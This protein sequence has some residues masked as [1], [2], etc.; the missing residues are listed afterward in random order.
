MKA[1]LIASLT[2]LCLPLIA[3]DKLYTSA[4]DS[5]PEAKAIL[6]ELHARFENYNAVEASFLLEIKIPEELPI[7][8]RGKVIRSGEKYFMDTKQYAAICNGE[9]IWLVLKDNQ[10]VQINEMPE[11]TEDTNILSPDAMFNFYRSEDFVYILA[12]QLMVDNQPAVQIEF[13]PLDRDSDYAK[14]RLSVHKKTHDPIQIEAFSKDGSSY[15]LKILS[16]VPNKSYGSEVFAFNADK[17]PGFHI[18]DLR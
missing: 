8:Q 7:E 15:T 2:I 10:E 17:Y 9:A 18:E 16:I 3:Q 5:D 11:E 6:D 4:A 13:K 12:N 14:L 1:I